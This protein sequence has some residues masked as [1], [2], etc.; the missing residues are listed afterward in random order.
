MLD[1]AIFVQARLGSTRFPKKILQKL[2]GKRVLDHVLDS[3]KE[4]GHEV[5]LLTPD[6]EKDFFSKSFNGI[7]R[8][9]KFFSKI[10]PFPQIDES[11]CNTITIE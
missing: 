5:F 10:S 7:F 2:A 4:T 6:S 11:F 3:C 8:L 1:Y 9:Q